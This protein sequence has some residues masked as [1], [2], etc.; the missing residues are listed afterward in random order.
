MF[1]EFK[2][3]FYPTFLAFPDSETDEGQYLYYD[4]A[5]G[6]SSSK[7]VMGLFAVGEQARRYQSLNDAD[8]IN[9]I[10]ADLTPVFGGQVRHSYVKHTVQ[11]WNEEL[12]RWGRTLLTAHRIAGRLNCLNL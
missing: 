4:A 11:N 6:H 12:S 8:L 2:H 10:F 9:Q 3:H 1:I 7:H 5:Y